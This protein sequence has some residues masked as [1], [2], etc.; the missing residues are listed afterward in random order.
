[1][2][3]SIKLFSLNLW[4]LNDDFKR[5]MQLIDQWVKHTSPNIVFLQEVS[6][7]P[8]S[9]R[10]QSDLIYAGDAS[11][12]RFYASQYQ[13]D[14][15]EE[16]LAILTHFPV[17]GVESMMLPEAENDGL[18][19]V[20]IVVLDIGG[21]R[22]VAANTH[23]AFRLGQDEARLE[24]SRHLLNCL[25]AAC[26]Y[27]KTESII[28]AGDFNAVPESPAVTEIT[29]GELPL[30]DIFAHTEERTH[31]FTASSTNPYV[32]SDDGADRWIDYIFTSNDLNTLSCSLAL[33]GVE[34]SPIASD[35]FALEA[36][37]KFVGNKLG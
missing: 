22:V 20:L 33:N 1:M 21:Q 15:R 19:R 13:W 27:Y 7:D 23:F 2:N 35:H 36:D 18:R 11:I 32:N 28:L 37:I 34:N 6:K 24:Q 8:D 14:E 29:Q 25:V 16:G 4:N 10:L 12:H 26:V 9:A 31:K 30:I 17:L 3:S 5:R